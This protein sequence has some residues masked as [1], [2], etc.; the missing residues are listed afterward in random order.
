L[1]QQRNQQNAGPNQRVSDI[2]SR[3]RHLF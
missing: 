2:S 1:E 3:S